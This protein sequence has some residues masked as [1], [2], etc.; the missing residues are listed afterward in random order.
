MPRRREP[1]TRGKLSLIEAGRNLEKLSEKQKS[2]Q[3]PADSV[4]LH[5][6]AKPSPDRDTPTHT[7]LSKATG[8]LGLV[9]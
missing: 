1:L 2:L 3:E 6:R 7:N 9:N 4:S 8:R 5:D